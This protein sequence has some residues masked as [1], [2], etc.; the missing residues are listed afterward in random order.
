[1]VNLWYDYSG[2]AVFLNDYIYIYIQGKSKIVSERPLF[3]FFLILRP[4]LYNSIGLLSP[5]I[6]SG[7]VDKFY[8]R[9]GWKLLDKKIIQDMEI[10][11]CVFKD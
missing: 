2:S 5:Y 1:M 3:F 4:I 10:I 7:A 6:Y 9:R 11:S 8:F